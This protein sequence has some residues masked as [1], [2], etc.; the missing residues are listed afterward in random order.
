MGR[1]KK[2]PKAPTNIQ[3][4]VKDNTN[5]SEIYNTLK[6]LAIGGVKTTNYNGVEIVTQPN[7]EAMKLLMQFAW[8]RVGTMDKNENKSVEA[9][10][11]FSNFIQSVNR[12]KH[13][14]DKNE[15]INNNETIE[16]NND[17]L[18]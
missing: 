9:M 7:M 5:W 14:A 18:N 13:I 2:I 17:T 3:E 10:A 12:P 11:A 4:F 16:N 8:G 1:H 15:S 6:S